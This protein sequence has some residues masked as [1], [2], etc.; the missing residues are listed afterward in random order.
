MPCLASA[1]LT[2]FERAAITE[3]CLSKTSMQRSTYAPAEAKM[4]AKSAGAVTY[5]LCEIS[6]QH[7]TTMDCTL[8]SVTSKRQ[9][10][11]LF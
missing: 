11:R 7:H 2:F 4:I 6:A 10:V 5:R 9:F 3:D 1:L 8:H